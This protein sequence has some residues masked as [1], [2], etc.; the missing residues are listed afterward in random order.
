MINYLEGLF[1]AN[2]ADPRISFYASLRQGG[3]SVQGIITHE[4]AQDKTSLVGNSD[5]A[6]AT[7]IGK[8]NVT[9]HHDAFSLIRQRTPRM[10]F[11]NAHVFNEFVD[12]TATAPHP[13]TQTAVNS[14]INAA[15]L[16][17][18]S[19]F[20]EVKTPLL[21]SGGGFITQRGSIWTLGGVPQT[22]N[23]LNPVNPDNLVFNPPSGFTW[24]DLTRLPYPYVLDPVDYVRNNLDKV[25]VIV[26]A[27]A[28]DQ[29]LL[30]SYLPLTA[31]F[32]SSTFQ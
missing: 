30:Q 10:R 29:A 8:L 28:A 9:Y 2:P 6:G 13:G 20:L 24:T 12:D 22:F 23:Q 27:N 16:V 5:T 1:Q 4:T 14:T 32:T 15:V 17:E 25:G 19:D 21:F 11:G 26:P 18:N 7:D 31:P 3:Q